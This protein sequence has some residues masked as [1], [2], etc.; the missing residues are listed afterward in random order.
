MNLDTVLVGYS[1]PTASPIGYFESILSPEGWENTRY[2]NDSSDHLSSNEIREFTDLVKSFYHDFPSQKE[3]Q[4][5]CSK[6][7][8]DTDAVTFSFRYDCALM[9]YIAHVTGYS[10]TFVPYR[11]ENA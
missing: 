10:V 8:T 2:V 3:L 9:T 7:G 5:Y 1:V 11:K 4:K 6:Y